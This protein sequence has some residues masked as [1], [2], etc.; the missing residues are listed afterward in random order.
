MRGPALTDALPVTRHTAAVTPARRQASVAQC[1]SPA[2]SLAAAQRCRSARSSPRK[3]RSSSR[4][5]QAFLC[6]EGVM[7]G[8]TWALSRAW[9]WRCT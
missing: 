8:C 9:R 1:Q 5:V 7:W 6:R 2:A 3:G 4:D